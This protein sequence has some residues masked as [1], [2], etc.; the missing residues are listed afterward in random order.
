MLNTFFKE[1]IE[2]MKDVPKSE[3][4]SNIIFFMTEETAIAKK[5]CLE[6]SHLHSHTRSNNAHYYSSF[7]IVSCM[8]PSSKNK[9]LCFLVINLNKNLYIKCLYH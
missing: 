9:Y 6:S 1:M 7:S 3:K 5:N 2:A 8:V 4:F